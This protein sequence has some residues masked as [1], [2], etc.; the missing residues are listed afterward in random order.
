MFSINRESL[1]RQQLQKCVTITHKNYLTNI[2][3]LE[4]KK[5]LVCSEL[6]LNVL[7]LIKY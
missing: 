2:V 6:N 3:I 7:H 1:H 4:I 5:H